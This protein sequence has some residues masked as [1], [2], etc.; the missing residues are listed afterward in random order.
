MSNKIARMYQSNQNK[1]N[2]TIF[3]GDYVLATKYS[4]GMPQDQWCIGFYDYTDP[5]Y[6]PVR[7]FVVDNNNNNFR[8]NGFRRMEKITPE[9]GKYILENRE[10]IDNSCF[11]LWWFKR[12]S[13]RV[14]N[15]KEAN[16]RCR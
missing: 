9:R 2:Q 8:F 6:T 13:M 15:C 3:P 14:H 5:R 11:S 4:D 10:K 1:I 16:E 12:C 7:H